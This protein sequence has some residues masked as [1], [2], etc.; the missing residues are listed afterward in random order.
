MRLQSR[1]QLGVTTNTSE[2]N[3]KIKPASRSSQSRA[4]CCVAVLYASAYNTIPLHRDTPQLY[5]ADLTTTMDL[6]SPYILR[7]YPFHDPPVPEAILEDYSDGFYRI[8]WKPTETGII[9]TGQ[10]S[11][12]KTELAN[13]Y[14]QIVRTWQRSQRAQKAEARRMEQNVVAFAAR[15]L[16][17]NSDSGHDHATQTQR[18]V[19]CEQSLQDG[20]DR[21]WRELRECDAHP[22]DKPGIRLC[23]G[24]RV[25][26]YMQGSTGFDR[27]LFMARGARVPV[28]QECAEVARSTDNGSCVC[29]S[30]WTC[31]RCRENELKI[32]AKARNKHITGLCEKCS[33]AGRLVQHVDF[34]S[35]LSQVQSVCGA[36]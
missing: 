9:C 16:D 23:K 20:M 30:Q 35:A 4:D 17:H 24:C 5:I 15:L 36:R 29:D 26:H 6:N 11:V 33:D 32:L 25:N 8:C 34:L 2:G 13:E 22:P 14:P 7:E 12:R 18:G 10:G 1:S 19:D 27:P 28:C 21:H 3:V 31:F